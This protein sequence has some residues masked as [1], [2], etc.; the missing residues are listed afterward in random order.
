MSKIKKSILLTTMWVLTAVAFGLYVYFTRGAELG[1][2]WFSVY[3]TEYMLSIDNLFIM[4][5]IFSYFKV[6]EKYQHRVLFYGIMGAF[7]FRAIF[8]GLGFEIVQRF[9][10]V[11]YLFG[12]LLIYTGIQILKEKNEKDQNL[13][14]NKVLR[15]LN[16]VLPIAEGHHGKKF[17]IRVHPKGTSVLINQNKANKKLHI[18]N[19]F[20][21]LLMI[22]FSDI[23]FAVDSI[24]ASFAISQ[25]RFIIF[26]ANAFALLGLRS[27]FFVVEYILHKFHLITK[28]LAIILFFI[29][30]KMLLGIF[31]LHISSAV[32]LA[33]LFGIIFAAVILSQ[34][35]PKKEMR[36]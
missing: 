19:L 32:S 1:F 8:I 36:V 27:L 18:T 13:D 26:T 14:T 20:L 21:C 28:A 22:E 23:I 2:Q 7:V 10:W 12:I 33:V 15:F 34:V 24:P 4:L 11:L 17:F 31:G 3:V 9:E 35:F 30:G 29:G 6:E 5:L 25:D 16:N